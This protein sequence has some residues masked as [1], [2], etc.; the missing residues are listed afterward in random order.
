MA[1]IA[2]EASVAV[3]TVH[4]TFHTKGHLLRELIRVVSAG[5]EDPPP[6][7]ERAWV[8]E[9][10]ASEHAERTLALSVEQGTDIFKRIAP[11][12]LAI[13]TGASVDPEVG[14]LWRSITAAR[15]AGIGKLLQSIAAKGQLKSGMTPKDATDIMSIIHSHEAFLE[16]VESCGWSVEEYKAWEYET[17][18]D[19]LLGGNSRP[20]ARRIGAAGLS[21]EDLVGHPRGPRRPSSGRRRA[22]R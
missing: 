12:R 9:A 5:E 15:R 14:E 13:E 8:R 2:I 17:L 3:Q 7:M 22:G 18:C 10:L 16:L 6:V 19:Q 21:F 20:S 4:F 1:A 11:L